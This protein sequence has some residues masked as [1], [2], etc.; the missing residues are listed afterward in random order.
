M[1]L[2]GEL[3][4]LVHLWDSS[5]HRQIQFRIVH[6]SRPQSR[7][8][9]QTSRDTPTNASAAPY[10]EDHSPEKGTEAWE[11]EEWRRPPP[12]AL[13]GCVRQCWTPGLEKWAPCGVAAGLAAL[14]PLFL[15]HHVT[16]D[17]CC[18]PVQAHC[19]VL[20][21]PQCSLTALQRWALLFS[22]L[23][24]QDC[25]SDSPELGVGR[26]EAVTWAWD[27]RA[28]ALPSAPHC[29]RSWIR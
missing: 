26:L 25:G 22:I 12:V 14:L 27:S 29:S 23:G 16:S 28:H 19:W 7:K 4:F 21:I 9:A 6:C 20:H 15:V 8:H 2:N 5:G 24:R 11:A 17:G 18:L 1:P 13:C 3:C 10:G